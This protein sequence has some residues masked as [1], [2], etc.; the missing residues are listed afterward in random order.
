VSGTITPKCVRPGT[1]ATI[2]VQTLSKSAVA[3]DTYYS[4]GK[5]GGQPPFGDG[6][7]GNAGGMT[8]ANGRYSSS[9]IVSANAP[10]GTAYARVVVGHAGASTETSVPFAVS[11]PR[12]AC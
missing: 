5:T 3:Y 1:Q 6:L 11:N 4:N 2:V 7:G 10:A 12:G 9:W 8:D